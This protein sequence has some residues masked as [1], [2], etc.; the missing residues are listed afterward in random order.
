MYKKMFANIIHKSKQLLND[1]GYA[2]MHA[3]LP[4]FVAEKKQEMPRSI[5]K[6]NQATSQTLEQIHLKY[7]LRCSGKISSAKKSINK[8]I[9]DKKKPVQL[10]VSNKKSGEVTEIKK[11]AE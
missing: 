1:P 11:I 5:S 9:S 4:S 6:A 8:S 10:K 2:T 7:R 3:P